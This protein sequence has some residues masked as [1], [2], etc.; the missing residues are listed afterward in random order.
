MISVASLLN[1]TPPPDERVDRQHLTPCSNRLIIETPSQPKKL[2]MPKDAAIFAKGKTK[3][4]VRYPPYESYSEDVMRKMGEF[5]VHP[6]KKIAESCKHI[7]YSSDKKPF[8]EKTGREGFEIFQYDFKGLSDERNYTV[9]WDYNIG[10]VRITPF[11]KCCGYSKASG[12]HPPKSK[13]LN[14]NPGLRDI[15]H[16]ITGGALAAQG[17]WMPFEAAKAVAATFCYYVRYA[18]VPI[19]G[20]DFLSLCARP[21]GPRYGL[22]IIDKDIVRR[23][24]MAANELR[25]LNNDGSPSREASVAPNSKPVTPRTP[26]RLLSKSLRPRILKI[27][28]EEV[29][30]GYGTDTDASERYAGS[31]VTPTVSVGGGPWGRPYPDSP[32]SGLSA[33]GRLKPDERSLKSVVSRQLTEAVTPILA[34][35]SLSLAKRQIPHTDEECK[36]GSDKESQSPPD[37]TPAPRKAFGRLTEEERAAYSIMEL[38]KADA[39]LR[40]RGSKRRRFSL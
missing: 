27:D 4:E 16:S 30:S 39:A 15:T 36:A 34:Y 6:T 38:H 14:M 19:F 37:A 11:F 35:E 28:R 33:L 31:P 29:E 40:S 20:E 25:L 5:K 3:G 13:M 7:P 1:P 24:T 8:L 23:C 9:M 18:F 22:M 32:T 21:E 12:T 26:K 2:K 10:L 17:Y